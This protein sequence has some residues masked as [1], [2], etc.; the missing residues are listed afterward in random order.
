MEQCNGH[1]IKGTL[2][3]GSPPAPC[4]HTASRRVGMGT[5]AVHPPQYCERCR[6]RP[7][8]WSVQLRKSE[9]KFT[10]CQSTQPKGRNNVC[11]WSPDQYRFTRLRPCQGQSGRQARHPPTPQGFHLLNS[12]IKSSSFQHFLPFFNSNH[13]QRSQ[14]GFE[15]DTRSDFRPRARSLDAAA[16]TLQTINLPCTRPPAK[17]AFSPFSTLSPLTYVF[18]CLRPRLAA[19]VVKI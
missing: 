4:G 3:W 17:R 8:T 18:L 16:S 15:L 6:F 19:R 12:R 9:L 11:S 14:H 2:H 7:T 1:T 5:E 10:F 13:L